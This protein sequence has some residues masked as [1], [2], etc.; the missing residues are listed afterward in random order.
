MMG[1]SPPAGFGDQTDVPVFSGQLGNFGGNTNGLIVEYDFNG[2]RIADGFLTSGQITQTGEFRLDSRD[3]HL[4]LGT[5]SI[6]ARVISSNPDTLERVHSDW[7]TV[8]FTNQP[9]LTPSGPEIAHVGANQA[10]WG[11]V[12][13]IDPSIA[14]PLQAEEL[15]FAG[16]H[17]VLVNPAGFSRDSYSQSRRYSPPLNADEFDLSSPHS[18]SWTLWYGGREYTV[19]DH[20]TW[21][22]DVEIVDNLWSYD[23][24]YTYTYTASAQWTA[25]DGTTY[26]HELSGSYSYSFIAEGDTT[27]GTS[28]YQ[29]LESR[30]DEAE[31]DWSFTG[32]TT[33]SYGTGV[34][35]RS[36]EE[37]GSQDY[38]L[39]A[40]GSRSTINGVVHKIENEVWELDG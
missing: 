29:L 15:A 17:A 28:F 14:A 39:D 36:G 7:R 21:A 31:L 13:D 12:I 1:P 5:T 40:S 2:D 25:G 22:V 26:D 30:D 3:Q 23:E 4:P 16:G 20:W 32:S 27:L 33:T 8:T 9:P 35:T 19:T 38:L 24:L 6:A 11:F 10:L 34:L 18:N 37:F